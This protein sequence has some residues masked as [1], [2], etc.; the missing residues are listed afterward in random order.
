M[1][2]LVTIFLLTL[3]ASLTIVWIYRLLLSWHHY[4]QSQVDTPRSSAWMKIAT[5]QGF[6]SFLSAPKEQ[7]KV[8]NLK[9][10][11]SGIKAP[12]GW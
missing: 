6:A 11:R 3:I 2:A 5:P 9:S 12:W 10:A 8:A 1:L 4:T 7:V